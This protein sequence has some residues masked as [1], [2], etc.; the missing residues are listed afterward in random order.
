MGRM[1]LRLTHMHEIDSP[2]V[3]PTF[4]SRPL[5]LTHMH[6][7]DFCEV[8][9]AGHRFILLLLL[10]MKKRRIPCVCEPMVIATRKL[11]AAH[12]RTL[13]S[14]PHMIPTHK[15]CLYGFVK[16]GFRLASPLLRSA[17]LP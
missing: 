13:S 12:G 4:V 7:I 10:F 11:I 6:E 14:L 15:A 2:K 17:V 9:G 1:G 8:Q 3:V 16:H 5:Q